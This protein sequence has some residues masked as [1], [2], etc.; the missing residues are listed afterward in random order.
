MLDGM[1]SAMLQVILEERSRDLPQGFV[2]GG[3]LQEN[4][5]AIAIFFNHS[6]KSSDLPFDTSK[7]IQ[8][9]GLDLRIN[10]NG[11]L[12]WSGVGLFRLA[13][14]ALYYTPPGVF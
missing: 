5:R 7:P 11:V 13:D 2:N 12:S 8:I 9:G 4:V 3:N 14:H 10:G 1:G 6:L